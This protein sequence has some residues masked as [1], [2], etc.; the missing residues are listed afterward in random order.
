[1]VRRPA[2][3]VWAVFWEVRISVAVDRMPALEDAL[4]VVAW[5]ART[6]VVGAVRMLHVDVARSRG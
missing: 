1:M 2:S 5:V 4:L 6:Q 3:V